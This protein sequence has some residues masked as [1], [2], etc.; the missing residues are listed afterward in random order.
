VINGQRRQ[1]SPPAGAFAGGLRHGRG[2]GV[3]GRGFKGLRCKLAN[4]FLAGRLM[5]QAQGALY[6]RSGGPPRHP[7]EIA[8]TLPISTEA[9]VAQAA[10]VAKSLLAAGQSMGRG[11]PAAP[12]PD[13]RMGSD[14]YLAAPPTAPCFLELGR[15]A[16]WPRISKPS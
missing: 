14:P 10:A 4:W 15:L 7:S 9:L 16:P 11:F 6:G 2:N 3:L 13:G 8:S 12:M 1:P 5:R